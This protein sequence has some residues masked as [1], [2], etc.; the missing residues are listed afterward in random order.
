[1]VLGAS[2]VWRVGLVARTGVADGATG[3]L[4]VDFDIEIL[5]SGF[6]AAFAPHHRSPVTAMKPTGRDL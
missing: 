6:V 2:T 5:R 3:G 1:M 4:F